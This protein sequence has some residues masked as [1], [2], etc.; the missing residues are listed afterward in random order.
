MRRQRRNLPEASLS[1]LD[2]ISC[3]FGAIVLL[4]II[5]KIGDPA[6]LAEIEQKLK[7][8]IETLQSQLFDIRGKSAELDAELSSQKQR[9]TDTRD[10][11]KSAK[12]K[13]KE[14]EA[15]MEST[16]IELEEINFAKNGLEEE[17]S[18]F[19]AMFQSEQNNLVAGIPTDSEYIIFIIDSSGSMEKARERMQ[20]EIANTLEIYPTVL[21]IQVMN[22]LGYYMFEAYKERWMP[23][24]PEM[25]KRINDKLKNWYA[26]D[27]SN[28]VKGIAKAI[29][30]F[31]KKG[32]KISLYVFGDEFPSEKSIERA[33]DEIDKLNR[34]TRGGEKLVRIHG[35]AFPT[36]FAEG[37]PR[38]TNERFAT[39]MRKVSYENGG[40][41]VGINEL[42]SKY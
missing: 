12:E 19:S 41:F 8:S 35:I 29:K 27:E 33:V 32:L 28:P 18:R 3:G 17:V 4:L 13:L 38:R 14:A 21:G 36:Y 37:D 30:D 42:E 16:A 15:D 7:E 22:G 24:S 23:D 11:I 20:R 9:L 26:V 10:K 1:F 25:R 6:T 34:P 40:A 31:H 2:I 5:A 39:L